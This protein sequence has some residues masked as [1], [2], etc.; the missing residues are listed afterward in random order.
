MFPVLLALAYAEVRG[1]M[2]RGRAFQAAPRTGAGP[3]WATAADGAAMQ[4]LPALQNEALT[5]H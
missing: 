1:T 3:L 5:A 4:S 2:P